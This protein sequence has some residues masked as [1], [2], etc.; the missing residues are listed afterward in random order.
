[1]IIFNPLLL[2][3]FKNYSMVARGNQHLYWISPSL[4]YNS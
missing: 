2:I 1:M 3:S 4:N